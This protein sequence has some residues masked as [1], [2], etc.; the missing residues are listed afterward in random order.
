M[1]TLILPLKRFTPNK[2]IQ[3]D[4]N[5]I[6]LVMADRQKNETIT[7][8]DLHHLQLAQQYHWFRVIRHGLSYAVAHGMLADETR[9]LVYLHRLLTDAAPDQFVDHRDSNGLSNISSNMRFCSR[10]ENGRNRASSK[11]SASKYKGVSKNANGW[12]SKIRVPSPDGTMGKQLYL[13]RFPFTEEGEVLA[14]R[15][16][17]AAALL[18]HGDFYRLNFPENDL[19]AA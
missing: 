12:A 15:T 4:G 14:A 7:I 10:S 13:G 16:F 6:G 9:K 18:F 3:L 19:V 2:T 8:I 17:D 5:R 11:G 1:N